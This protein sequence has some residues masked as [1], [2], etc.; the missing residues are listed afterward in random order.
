MIASKYL[1]DE[2]SE[3]EVFNDEWANS[4]GVDVS[5][6][7]K[8]EADFLTAIDWNLYIHPHQFLFMLQKAE[9]E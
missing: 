8:L 2:G 6:V 5:K 1:Y 7:N 3:D 9:S 4:G